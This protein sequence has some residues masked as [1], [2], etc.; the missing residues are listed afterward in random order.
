MKVKSYLIALPKT[1]ALFYN[2]SYYI[3]RPDNTVLLFSNDESRKVAASVS[4]RM[5][6]KLR[7]YARY[8]EDSLAKKAVDCPHISEV[9]EDIKKQPPPMSKS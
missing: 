8:Q 1:D 6:G 2:V 4:A 3:V 7:K 5:A 9:L